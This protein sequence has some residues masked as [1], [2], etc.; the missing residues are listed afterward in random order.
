MVEINELERHLTVFVRHVAWRVVAGP[1][2]ASHFIIDFG[3]ERHRPILNRNQGLRR[4]RT[5][6]LG[7]AAA[8]YAALANLKSG[9]P[10]IGCSEISKLYQYLAADEHSALENVYYQR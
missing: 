5:H 7:A 1:S 8:T 3:R 9:T 4:G 6:Y 2:T 10:T